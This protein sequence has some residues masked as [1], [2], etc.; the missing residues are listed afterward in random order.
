MVA[1]STLPLVCLGFLGAAAH[2]QVPTLW[3]VAHSANSQ[4]HDRTSARH[5]AVHPAGGV[6]GTCV[7]NTYVWYAYPPYYADVRSRLVRWS[8]AGQELW[9]VDLAGPHAIT[10]PLTLRVGAQGVSYVVGRGAAGS[11]ALHA[12]DAA[13][14]TLWTV[15]MAAGAWTSALELAPDKVIVAG[16]TASSGGDL[17]VRAWTTG[18]VPLWT[19]TID[20]PGASTD[21]ATC[22]AVAPNGDVVVAGKLE[23]GIG[24]ARLDAAGAVL[25]QTVLQGP[26]WSWEI[27]NDVA[28]APD[29]DV[30][31]GGSVQATYAGDAPAYL[32]RLDPAGAVRWER[33]WSSQS[34]QSGRLVDVDV[35]PDGS[36]WSLLQEDGGPPYRNVVSL[37]RHGA[38]GT[39]LANAV[40]DTPID[41]SS[42]AYEIVLGSAGD[43]HVVGQ[44]TDWP[45]QQSDGLLLHLDRA[46]AF[47]W[48]QLFEAQPGSATEFHTAIALVSGD[49]IFTGGSTS[50]NAGGV[51]A[52]R[53]FDVSA[54]PE[55]YCAG[56]VNSLGCT[57]SLVF[58]GVSS[59]TAS[60]GFTVTATQELNRRR[61]MILYSLSGP[62][63]MP[64]QGGTLCVQSPVRRTP[65]QMS[66]GSALPAN[67][68]TGSYALD[69]NAYAAGL[70]GGQPDPALRVPGTVV[71]VQAWGRD[72]GYAAPNDTSLSNGLR[73]VVGP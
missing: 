58:E 39:L 30:L 57:P 69:W 40:Y 54:A 51:A 41:E 24:V 43:V 48:Q 17:L 25:W 35:A 15:P 5:L 60:S 63:T 44:T 59:A 55:G 68:C 47:L 21:Y 6:V 67:D 20:G 53:A 14:A 23:P 19:T 1:R 36:T 27:A 46:G 62:A 11:A 22:V 28:V 3:N 10:S 13:G 37:A 4:S 38:D 56:K 9:A 18:G 64:F 70:A 52:V 26:P 16:A 12:I 34:P 49:R 65:L 2:A 7:V 29:G 66:G 32:A 31:V 72:P 50:W 61:G 71:W 33:T 45:N 8:D 73:Y 42:G